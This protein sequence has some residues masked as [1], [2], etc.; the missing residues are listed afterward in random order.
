MLEG[1]T[2]EDRLE[3]I[4]GKRSDD[5]EIERVIL[6]GDAIGRRRVVARGLMLAPASMGSGLK[7]GVT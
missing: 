5:P 3:L 1:D 6:G 4:V 2:E 7:G